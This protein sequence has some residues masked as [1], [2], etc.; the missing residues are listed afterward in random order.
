MNRGAPSLRIVFFGSLTSFSLLAFERL[1]ESHQVVAAVLARRTRAGL[2][3]SLRRFVTLIKPSPLERRAREFGLPLL[4]VSDALE[5]ATLERLRALR[6]DLLCT[7]IFP[8]KLPR[9]AID[10]AALGAI[11]VHPSLLP[12]HR[13]PLPLFWVYYHDDRV[14]G[15]TVHHASDRFDAGDIILQESFPLPRAYPMARLDEDV[16]HRGADLLCSAVRQLTLGSAER[17]VQDERAA[18]YA[19]RIGRGVPMVRF[20]E[21][22]VERVRHFLE[23]LCPLFRE[24]LVDDDGRLVKYARVT[25]YEERATWRTPGTVEKSSGGWNLHCRGGVVLL[26]ARG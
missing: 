18:T 7:A 24:P 12:R 8:F 4:P 20:D 25:G 13:G 21:W 22:E 3:R 14:T 16:A 19:P 10:I 11:N 26:A 5:S 17:R 6:P 15:V 23:A 1:A 2:R 9:E